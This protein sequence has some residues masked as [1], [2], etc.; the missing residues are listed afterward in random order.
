MGAGTELLPL[1]HFY[2]VWADGNWR[3]PLAEHLAA[4]DESGFRGVFAVGL[5]GASE[6]R[7]AVIDALKDR[8]APEIVA[9]GL[10]GFEAATLNAARAYAKSY[11]G[12][13]LYAHTK[14]A[15]TVE[16]FRDRWRRSMTDRVVR[17]WEFNLSALRT[18]DAIGCHWLTEAEHPG[19]FGPM[20][21]PAEGSGFFGGNF[22]MARCDYLRTLPP[23]EDEPRWR[24]ESWIGLNKPKVIDL[25][26]GWPQDNRWPHLCE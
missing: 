21:V 16:P 10:S 8:W 4:L 13:V 9:E 14:G 5:I 19:M 18:V 12:A 2:H 7:A 20:T 15:A 25:L 17:G 23:C 22:W 11:D 6:N 24:C 1:A 3:V 26:P